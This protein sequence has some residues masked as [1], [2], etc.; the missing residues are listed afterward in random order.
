MKKHDNTTTIKSNN[1][2]PNNPAVNRK[3]KPALSAKQKLIKASAEQRLQSQ[4]LA[5][6]WQEKLFSKRQISL[7]LLRQAAA[8]LQPQTYD[9]VVEERAVQ[10]YCGYPLCDRTPQKNQPRYRISLSQRK[11]Y[12]QSELA[13]YCSDDC[14]QKSKYFRMQL[15]EEPVWFRDLQVPPPIQIVLPSEDLKKVLQREKEDKRKDRTGHQIR[16]DYVQ[17]LLENVPILPTTGTLTANVTATSFETDTGNEIRII[18]NTSPNAVPPNMPKDGIHDAIEGFQIQMRRKSVEGPTTLVL[19]H[20]DQADGGDDMKP[21]SPTTVDSETVVFE[22][23]EALLEDA[24]ETMMMLKDLQADKPDEIKPKASAPSHQGEPHQQRAPA[25]QALEMTTMTTTLPVSSSELP[26]S[27]QQ[28]QQKP[29]AAAP[30]TV[31]V[32]IPEIPKP[33]SKKKKRQVPEMSLF[34]KIWTMTDRLT[35]KTTRRYFEELKSQSQVNMRELLCEEDDNTIRDEV[36]LMRG[37]IFS[38]RIL[39]TYGLVRAQ[40]GLENALENDIINLIQT[41]RFADA[42]MVVLN[43]SEAY[44][45]TLVLFKALADVTIQNTSWQHNFE[46]CCKAIGESGDKVDACVRVLRVAS[47]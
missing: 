32:V 44:M 45:M 41:F 14:M 35:T 17:K 46:E 7:H 19:Q 31:K 28:Q 47:T 29:K 8:I 16:I 6:S 23:E 21:L 22:D 2:R 38:E 30:K 10:D 15:S 20:G 27:S 5:F 4:E 33:S 11:V 13:S 37:Q 12:D 9:E 25:N 40:M 36:S 39:E 18:E 24:M 26:S 42:S 43:S 3:Q 1:R 34:G